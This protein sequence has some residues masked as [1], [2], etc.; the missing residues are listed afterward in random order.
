MKMGVLNEELLSYCYRVQTRSW[1][2]SNLFK[3]WVNEI[4]SKF[5]TDGREVTLVMV[6][7]PTHPHM[8]LL[9]VNL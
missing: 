1:E 8:Q 5:Q 9:Q 2:G 7:C 6:N 4:N 3:E